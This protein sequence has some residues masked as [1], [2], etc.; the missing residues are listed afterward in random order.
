MQQITD[1]IMDEELGGAPFVILRSFY[2]QSG[3]EKALTHEDC[4]ETF[5]IVHPAS[6][7]ELELVPE[8]YRHLPAI[9]IH[10]PVQL[11]LGVRQSETEF[12]GPDR[13]VY[14]HSLYLLILVRDWTHF[15]FCRGIAVLQREET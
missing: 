14:Q 2:R 5:G 13:I 7:A 15:G 11:S 8:E 9:L 6:P 1:L 12:S 10:S 4:Y 3:G